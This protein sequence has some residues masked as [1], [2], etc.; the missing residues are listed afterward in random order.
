V[1]ALVKPIGGGDKGGQG[2]FSLKGGQGGFS[3][4]QL[5][6]A[7]AAKCDQLLAQLTNLVCSS[8]GSMMHP[9]VLRPNKPGTK[10][11]T[12]QDF[13]AWYDRTDMQLARAQECIPKLI[14]SIEWAIASNHSAD[15]DG[16]TERFAPIAQQ[17]KPLIAGLGEVRGNFRWFS[18]ARGGG[19]A[20][21]D[22]L[23]EDITNGPDAE[24]VERERIQK[25]VNTLSTLL[26]RSIE[27]IQEICDYYRR[28]LAVYTRVQEQDLNDPQTNASK[29]DPLIQRIIE[30][31]RGYLN[32]AESILTAL[33]IVESDLNRFLP[34][35]AK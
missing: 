19:G 22:T 32:H 6:P 12:R 27:C 2:G 35:S 30:A 21:P 4:D 26:F 20:T 10:N 8:H 1:V 15:L 23:D 7:H 24:R 9:D 31:D 5:Q 28:D 33:R 3:L 16:L 17:L 34:K 18:S 13:A 11:L 14:R 25:D 29:R